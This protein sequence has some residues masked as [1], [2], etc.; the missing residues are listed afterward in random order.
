M[1]ESKGLSAAAVMAPFPF[2]YV[3]RQLRRKN[4]GILS[5]VA[6]EGRAHSV[7]VVYGVSPP[8]LPFSL[9]LITRPTLKKA[10]NIRSN[11]NVS[12][13]VP[14]PHHFFRF[15]PASCVQFQ[16]R[17]QLLPSD[18]SVANKVFQSSLVLRQSLKHTKNLGEPVFIRIVSDER[19]FTWGIGASVWQI[20]RHAAKNCYVI[21][22]QNRRNTMDKEMGVLEEHL[23]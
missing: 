1:K 8:E 14:F 16:G 23:N 10:R 4:T 9:Y 6:P 7:G 15:V 19:I 18:D 11:P 22:P 17:A 3:E 2:A 21:I 5:T 20:I 12:F 13:V